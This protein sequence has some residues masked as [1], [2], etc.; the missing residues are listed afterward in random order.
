MAEPKERKPW[1]RQPGEPQHAYATMCCYRDLGP[2]RSLTAAVRQWLTV[3]GDKAAT[4]RRR[5]QRR[6]QA[7][8]K[9]GGYLHSVRQNWGRQ[10]VKWH[11][12]DR[13][14]AHDDASREEADHRAFEAQ[15]EEKLAEQ[16]ENERQRGLRLQEARQL[17]ETARGGM[18]TAA[19][20][21]LAR[22][23]AAQDEVRALIAGNASPEKVTAAI[24]DA[25]AI[26]NWATK[27]LDIAHKL[28]ALALGKATD[29]T[30]V[31]FDTASIDRLTDIITKRLPEEQW[32]DVANEVATVLRGQHDER[33]HQG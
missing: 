31:Q 18:V 14:R 11:W 6:Y 20:V 27:S 7:H 1:E 9:P 21:A 10:S 30:V 32:E 8:P 15:V 19:P 24:T 12:V 23:R 2:N 17:A 13:C 5:Q 33:P 3:P 4:K 16:Q 28:E 29:R 25:V 26:L 22:L